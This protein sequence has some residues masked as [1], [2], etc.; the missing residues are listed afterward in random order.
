LVEQGRDRPKA[1]A[2]RLAIAGAG[3][4]VTIAGCLFGIAG[5]VTLLS[6]A[7]SFS[8]AAVGFLGS[9]SAAVL[10]GRFLI[11]AASKGETQQ[12]AHRLKRWARLLRIP[13][14][15]LCISWP[16]FLLAAMLRDR[17]TFRLLGAEAF[18]QFP[19]RAYG[20]LAL[21]AMLLG[22]AAIGCAEMWGR[23]PPPPD[24]TDVFS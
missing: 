15:L 20:T 12:R 21:P 18:Y 14:L 2:W 13:G 8:Y 22:L 17:E 3:W 16:C 5:A 4:L 10:I 11:V 23:R 6:K 7:G 19:Y 9:I 1:P 24:V